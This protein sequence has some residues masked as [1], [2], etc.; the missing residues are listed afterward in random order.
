MKICII[1]AGFYG[2]Y[3]ANSLSDLGF[4]IDLFEKNSEL[5]SGAVSNNQQRLHMGFHYPRCEKTASQSYKIFD[6]FKNKFNSCVFEV[7]KNIYCIDKESK[8]NFKDY[9]LFFKNLNIPFKEVDIKKYSHFFNKEPEGGI[10]V[11]EM[12]INLRKLKNFLIESLKTKD[13]NIFLN[14]KIT[15]ENINKKLEIYDYVINC[16][17]ND[18]NISDLIN[19]KCKHEA[20]LVPRYY[21]EKNSAFYNKS[22]GITIMDGEFC[23]LYPSDDKNLF[24]LSNVK[25]TPFIKSESL[26]DLEKNLLNY[27]KENFEKICLDIFNHS[28][29]FLKL[30]NMKYN[31]FYIAKKT[32]ILNDSGDD[33]RYSFVKNKDNYIVIFSGKISVVAQILN[34]ILEILNA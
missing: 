7:E 8:V 12:C 23:S 30:N 32:K 1:G 33:S 15:S 19:I 5:M 34:K 16:T 20:C 13:I 29:K 3:L 11:D 26:F 21:A 24:T 2:C 14:S 17:Y 4:K 9:K 31:D 25:L 22:V 27:K 28:S 10:L 18:I 6:Y